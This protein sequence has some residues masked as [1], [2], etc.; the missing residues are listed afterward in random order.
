MQDNNYSEEQNKKKLFVG[1]LPFTVTEEGLRDLFA[2]YGELTAATLI[3]DK[4]SGRSKGFGF[5]EFAT[6]ED[7]ASAVA[8]MADME[9]EGRKLI[10]NVARPKAPREDRGG[11]RG[12]YRGGNSSYGSSRGGSSY[13]NN[14]RGGGSRDNNRGGSRY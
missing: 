7:A 14:S 4:F 9:V 1:N 6:E 12:G 5:V 2:G 13:G 3:T 8:A 10:V 11:D